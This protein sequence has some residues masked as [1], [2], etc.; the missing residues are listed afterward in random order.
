[1][2]STVPA[3]V[4]ATTGDL[5]LAIAPAS[6]AAAFA[7]V[8]DPRRRASIH[9]PVAAILALTVA[10]VLAG[11]RSVLAI[12]EW[13]ARQDP[14]L[15]TALGFSGARTPCQSTL[16]RL[17]RHLD[18]DALATTLTTF[19][20][21]AAVP[22]HALQGVAI[23]GK[24]QRGRLAFPTTGC[25]IHALSA[26]C[27]TSGLI[28][29]QEPITADGDKAEAELSVAPTLLRRIDWHDRV[30]TG[31]ALFCQRGLCAQV[32]DAGGDYLVLVKAN[33]PALYE[34]IALLFDPPAD[35]EVLPL[36]DRREATTWERGHGRHHER[37]QLVAS[38]DLN[39][40]LDWPGIAQVFRVERSWQAR[41]QVH[42]AVQYG[43]TS[44]SPTQADAAQLLAL[45]RGH[46]T[47]ENAVHRAKDVTF[48]ED[49]SLIHLGHGPTVLALV[50]DAALNLLRQAGVRQITARL[51]FHAQ[52]PHHAVALVINPLPPRA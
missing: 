7:T 36:L 45:R 44:L 38:T 8:P 14:L 11:Q 23:D 30:V 25:P 22:T 37:R 19:I 43:I 6:L 18:G 46:W 32:Q 27:H 50:R 17:F 39:A 49:A 42:R 35:L 31:D 16:H 26:V 2:Q 21:P 33:Q 3:P 10:A 29:A 28:L 47:I 9:Y 1:M 52:Y 20:A 34:A 40:Y 5:A 15:L 24:T 51:R 4:V 41:G 13:S 48:G 12:A